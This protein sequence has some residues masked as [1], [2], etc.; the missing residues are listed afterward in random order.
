VAGG[1][2]GF[3]AGDGCGVV[4]ELTRSG[5]NW[6]ETTLYNFEGLKDGFGPG[7]G[8]VFD[9]AGNLFG[10]TPDGGSHSAGVVF[11]LSPT[12]T[13]WKQKVIHAFTGG[14]DG[15]SGSLGLLLFDAAG[16]L[17]GTSEL[18]GHQGAGAVYKLSPGV[19][20]MWKAK[21]LYDFKGTPDGANP[22]GGLILDA[23]GNL[24]G[25]TY[26]GGENGMGAVF[27]LTPGPNGTWQEI[28]L[29][30][31]QGGTDGSL[32][33]TTLIFNASASTL[34]G[35]T[36]TGGRPSCDCGTVF[37]LTLSGG[38]WKEKIVH[39]FGVGRDGSYP[40]YGLTLDQAGNLYGTAPV[41]GNEGQGIIFQIAP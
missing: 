30:S 33:T 29:Y 8:L 35:T 41:G 36:S 25:T 19:G 26:Y 4:F 39:F 11:E 34:Y 10:T 14:K 22:Y 2:G 17:Y 31:F 6:T 5:S 7:S 32:P 27:E 38:N 18:G 24:Y 40:N 1:S 16:N 13:G 20:G 3:C 9:D 15:A 12:K 23:A 37:K 28:L 21:V